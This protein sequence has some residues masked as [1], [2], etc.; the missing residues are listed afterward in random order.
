MANAPTLRLERDAEPNVFDQI[1]YRF[2][3][4]LE[5]DPDIVVGH[6]LGSVIAY[7]GLC[8][9]PHQVSTFLTLGSPIGVRHLIYDK[10]RPRDEEPRTAP[11]VGKWI[12]IS[13]EADAL[14]VPIPRI[15][16]LFRGRVTDEV[17][18]QG[19]LG[20]RSLTKNHRF[21]EYLKNARVGEIVTD[22]VVEV[23]AGRTR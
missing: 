19:K 9:N 4:A 3:K 1:Q 10:L 22:A 7:E 17:I 5:R 11:S 18:R 8:R 21:V 14:V 15:R 6:S 13:N 23:E 12:N 16:E 20:L 2:R